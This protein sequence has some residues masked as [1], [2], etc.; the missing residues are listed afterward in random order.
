MHGDYGNAMTYLVH[1]STTLEGSI[2]EDDPLLGSVALAIGSI[3]FNRGEDEEALDYFEQG[4][5][6][7][8]FA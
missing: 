8:S 3:S 5:D 2:D 7:S 6:P 1:S 4:K